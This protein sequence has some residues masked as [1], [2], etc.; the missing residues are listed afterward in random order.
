[1]EIPELEGKI[2][3]T[4]AADLLGLTRQSINKMI[5]SGHFGYVRR[6]GKQ[7]VLDKQEVDAL[8]ESRKLHEE[9]HQQNLAG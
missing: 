5:N 1:M 3:A 6:L 2:T 4:D 9:E 7:F 8:V